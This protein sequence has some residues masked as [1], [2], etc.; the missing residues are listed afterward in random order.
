MRQK[1]RTGGNPAGTLGHWEGGRASDGQAARLTGRQAI[2]TRRSQMATD[3]ESSPASGPW[4]RAESVAAENATGQPE[5]RQEK[6]RTD[7]TRSWFQAAAE[8][9]WSTIISRAH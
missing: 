3:R 1:E 9:S 5:R 6:V 8:Q 2:K 4:A 7:A